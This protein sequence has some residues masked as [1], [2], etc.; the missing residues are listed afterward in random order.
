MWV[1]LTISGALVV[2]LGMAVK[3][4]RSERDSLEN[5][6]IELKS[7]LIQYR[8]GHGQDATR[9]ERVIESHKARVKQLERIVKDVLATCECDE[10][11]HASALINQL[12]SDSKA[13]LDRAQPGVRSPAISPGAKGNK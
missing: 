12:F 7:R 11:S 5:K 2:I 13:A 9:L 6:V 4:L 3:E 10:A 8:Q 1:A